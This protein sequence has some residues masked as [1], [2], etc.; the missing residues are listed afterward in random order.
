M[1]SH[2]NVLSHAQVVMDFKGIDLKGADAA[3]AVVLPGRSALVLHGAARYAWQAH[4]L[5]SPLC[6]SEVY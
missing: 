2:Q 6:T 3:K 5:K 4:I 1:F